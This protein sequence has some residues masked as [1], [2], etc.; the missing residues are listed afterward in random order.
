M[1]PCFHLPLSLQV[2]TRNIRCLPDVLVINCE[3]NSSKE[4]DF[5]KTQAEV[6]ETLWGRSRLVLPGAQGLLR[7][8]F[9][10]GVF[11]VISL[12]LTVSCSPPKQHRTLSA[13]DMLVFGHACSTSCAFGVGKDELSCR[14][15]ADRTAVE[16][17]FHSPSPLGPRSNEAVPASQSMGP[18]EPVDSWVSLAVFFPVADFTAP[19]FSPLLVWLSPTCSRAR[20][21]TPC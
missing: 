8:Q 5:W 18:A 2:Q 4:A 7:V 11:P 21:V 15:K 16:S 17:H 6:G 20:P 19:V 12:S 13:E 10:R 3:V 1:L 14:G 9:C